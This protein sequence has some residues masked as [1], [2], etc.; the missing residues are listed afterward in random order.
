MSNFAAEKKQNIFTALLEKKKKDF[1][2]QSEILNPWQ[3][4]GF[5]FVPHHGK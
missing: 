1:V 2:L 3:L 5:F 4:Y